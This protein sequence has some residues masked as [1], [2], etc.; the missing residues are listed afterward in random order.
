[1]QGADRNHIRSFLAQ[2]RKTGGSARTTARKLAAIRAA[3]AFYVRTGALSENPAKSVRAPKIGRGLPDAL[4]IPEVTALV[5]APE[6]TDALGIRDRALLEVLYSTGIRA[7]ELT[8]LGMRDVDLIGGTVRVLGK[9]KKERLGYLGSCAT[10]ALQR[11]FDVRASL[12]NPSHEQVFVNAR[13]GALTTRSVQRIVDKYAR[14]AL[15]DH[16]DVSPHTLRHTF[17]THML[18]GGADLRVV[19]EM[20]GH[21]SL[22]S[23]Q[24]YTHVGIDRLKA[25]YRAAHP[26]A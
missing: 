20:L 3:Y 21:E 5:E 6:G 17:A 15:P 10:D 11:Y 23:T 9:R 1:L 26:H 16:R 4:S 24:I 25:V 13:G 2:V 7:A 8:G 14:T 22:S 18:N 12:G 19:Q